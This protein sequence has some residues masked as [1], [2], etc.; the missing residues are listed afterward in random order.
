MQYELCRYRQRMASGRER[1]ELE[2]EAQT[3]A[4]FGAMEESDYFGEWTP[5]ERTPCG[6]RTRY[7]KADAGVWFVEG[8]ATWF[9]ATVWPLLSIMDG[10][11]LNLACVSAAPLSAY[12]FW[13]LEACALAVYQLLYDMEREGLRA[14]IT[15]REDLVNAIWRAH[16]AF[17][18]ERQRF[19]EIVKKVEAACGG[20]ADLR[21]L[22][23]ART[24]PGDRA[25]LIKMDSPLDGR[26]KLC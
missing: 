10:E 5:P 3:C 22:D 7:R 12:A 18:R 6:A 8:G 15:S 1:S 24:G 11:A 19:A 26:E 2:R 9:L 20:T 23:F 14:W 13:P 17:A 25:F 21:W 16:P 4:L